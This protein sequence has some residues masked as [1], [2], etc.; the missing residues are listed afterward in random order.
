[1]WQVL[2]TAAIAGSTGLVAKNLFSSSNADPSIVK[3][4]TKKCDDNNDDPQHS[5]ENMNPSDLLSQPLVV[6]NGF[7]ESGFDSNSDI[8]DGIFTFSSSEYPGGDG[9]IKKLRKKSRTRCPGYGSKKGVGVVEK[10]EQKCSR[11][12]VPLEQKKSGRRFT[13]CLKRRKTNKTQSGKAGFCSSKD[14][15]L[16]GWGL[17]IGIMYMMSTGKSEIS[18]LNKAMDETAGVVEELKSELHRRKSSRRQ[19]ILNSVDNINKSN[20]RVRDSN[21]KVTS[22]SGSDDGKCGSSVL[23][24]EP[25]PQVLEMDQLE[26]ELESELQKLPWCAME[27]PCDEEMRLNLHEIE[28]SDKGF[29]ETEGPIS[30]SCQIHG[31]L[32]SELDQKLS[33]LLIERQEDQIGELESEL[34]L[35]QSKLLEKE[36]ELHALK[37][38]VR[39]LTKFS[40]ST[41]SDDE[42]EN[43]ANQEG[44]SGWNYNK[45][46]SGSKHSVVG[47]KRPIDS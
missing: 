22:L 31:V 7:Y 12:E 37:D 25:D 6:P 47:M 3:E 34:H 19:K 46:D 41:V 21:N 26:A 11:A 16:F 44:I 28:G 2:L 42:T 20:S 32:P 38:C 24:E 36:A 10:V 33:H 39:R 43:H 29:H 14:N 35:A 27:A 30:K 13:V 1:M 45:V 9:L 5:F 4:E 23:T 8:Q 15:S 18:K 17:G 40:I